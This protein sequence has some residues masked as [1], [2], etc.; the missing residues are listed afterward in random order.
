MAPRKGGR[1][2]IPSL[3]P[4]RFVAVLDAFARAHGLSRRERSVLSLAADAVRDKEIAGRLGCTA[5]TMDALWR[6]IYAK[7]GLRAHDAV[8]AGIL[9]LSL[10][11]ASATSHRHD[12]RLS[13]ERSGGSDPKNF[14]PR[15]TPRPGFRALLV[16]ESPDTALALAEQ[17]AR[18]TRLDVVVAS[19]PEPLISA[20]TK[21]FD[22][23]IVELGAGLSSLDWSLQMRG[24]LG[25]P[26]LVFV[27]DSAVDA[28][29]A[30][31]RELG[32]GPILT[33]TSLTDWLTHAAPSLV[34][35]ARARRA[36]VEAGAAL[37]RVP[38]DDAPPSLGLFAAEQRFRESYVRAL[39]GRTN[40]RRDAAAEAHICY[41]TF[42]HIIKKLGLTRSSATTPTARLTSPAA[43]PFVTRT[44]TPGPSTGR[45][46]AC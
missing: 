14:S 11:P 45:S 29:A 35:M 31:L 17:L 22:I 6:R 25:Q 44:T 27:A 40:S 32:I 39:I 36:L 43:V 4:G 15:R 12:T 10:A 30:G 5:K 21:P 2:A 19:P 23:A 33:A 9:Q 13:K 42:C 28:G 46:D 41:R 7:T 16:S 1:G 37:P 18:S 3:Q 24:A 26:E 38:D 34:K 8:L 20:R